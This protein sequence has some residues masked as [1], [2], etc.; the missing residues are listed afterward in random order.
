MQFL[1]VRSGIACF[2]ETDWS[3][4]LDM[5]CGIRNAVSPL[6]TANSDTGLRSHPNTD[7]V[8]LL[9]ENMPLDASI[10]RSYLNAA[11]ETRLCVRWGDQRTRL[12]SNR[13]HCWK[14]P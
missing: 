10:E 14:C 9:G 1:P 7:V 6:L 2:D 8:Q 5:N 12:G 4:R 3:L 11:H 13:S